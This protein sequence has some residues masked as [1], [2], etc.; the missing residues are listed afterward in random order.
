MKRFGLALATLLVL[1]ATTTAAWA[2]SPAPPAQEAAK[3]AAA[4]VRDREGL[5]RVEL[6]R[7]SG[8]LAAELAP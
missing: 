7:A 5:A 8:R 4:A 3:P 1:G 6:A 2:Q